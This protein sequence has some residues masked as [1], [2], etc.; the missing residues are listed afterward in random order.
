[1]VFWVVLSTLMMTWGIK[2]D[3]PDAVHINYGL[4]LVWGIHTVSMIV[5]PVDLWKIDISALL[6]DLLFWQGLMAAIGVTIVYLF[7]RKIHDS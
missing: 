3:W 1:M 7:N 2:V 6:T 5:G 4:P